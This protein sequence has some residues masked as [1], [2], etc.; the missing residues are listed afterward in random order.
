MARALPLTY[1]HDDQFF[2]PRSFYR[3]GEG[4]LCNISNLMAIIIILTA[5]YY[6]CPPP[7]HAQPAALRPGRRDSHHSRPPPVEVCGRRLTG[8]LGP[9]STS[10]V[11]GGVAGGDRGDD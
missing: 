1:L 6:F 8:Q 9:T 11:S 5:S 7:P 4:V 3:A 10:P 2:L